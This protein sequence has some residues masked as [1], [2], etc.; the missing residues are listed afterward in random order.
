MKSTVILLF[1]LS[2]SVELFAT[3]NIAP[4]LSRVEFETFEGHFVR[5]KVDENRRIDYF[6]ISANETS[7][8][9]PSKDYRDIRNPLLKGVKLFRSGQKYWTVQ[10][11]FRFDG[12]SMYYCAWNFKF[13]GTEYVGA[14]RVLRS[15]RHAM[16]AKIDGLLETE[17]HQNDK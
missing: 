9:I 5:I 13:E 4:H 11:P 10:V 2:P 14:V 6:V 12:Q 7:L 8:K 3:P 16:E 17:C 1:L 15:T